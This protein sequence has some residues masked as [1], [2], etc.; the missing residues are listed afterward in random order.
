MHNYQIRLIASD[1]DHTLLNSQ[2][3]IPTR[4]QHTLA[5]LAAVGIPWV[6]ISGR[7]LPTMVQRFPHLPWLVAHNGAVIAHG[8]KPKWSKLLPPAQ[9]AAVLTLAQALNV[10]PVLCRIDQ[11]ELLVHDAEH[12]ASLRQFFAQVAVVSHFSHL[13]DVAKVTLL[14]PPAR[15]ATV[16]QRLQA[17]LPPA[18]QIAAGEADALAITAA[19]VNKGTA[20]TRLC[21]WLD[22]PLASVLAFGD[23]ANDAS[24]L[25]KAGVGMRMADGDPGLSECTALVAPANAANGVG[26]VLD[27]LL[28]GG[29]WLNLEG[30]NA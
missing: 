21:Q 10:V 9:V 12:A 13:T 20:L 7:D 4:T 26:Q 24:L 22:V 18:V 15:Q 17:A 29:G 23:A 5:A 25:H 1:L 6:P 19:G 8:G 11:A 28:A 27:Q 2:G 30:E 3:E 14:M 16:A